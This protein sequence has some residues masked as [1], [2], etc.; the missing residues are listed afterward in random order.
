MGE[1]MHKVLNSKRMQNLVQ[2]MQNDSRWF[3]S[4]VKLQEY[5]K[6]SLIHV[7]LQEKPYVHSETAV[8]LRVS[9]NMAGTAC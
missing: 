2:H 7:P 4:N 5:A 3:T 9:F 8:V 6:F 1:G